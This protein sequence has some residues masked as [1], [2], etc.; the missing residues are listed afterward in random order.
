MRSPLSKVV[1]VQASISSA[2]ETI[3]TLCVVKIPAT[4]PLGVSCQ[5]QSHL[6]STSLTFFPRPW[7]ICNG[8]QKLKLKLKGGILV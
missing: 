2:A 8:H 6:F 1:E 4:Y 5:L 3:R 7:L